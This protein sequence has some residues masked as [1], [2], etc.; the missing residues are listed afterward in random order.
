MPK[1]HKNIL[2]LPFQVPLFPA[3]G[4]E[5]NGQVDGR[6]GTPIP[7]EG[8]SG[9]VW[10][11]REFCGGIIIFILLPFRLGLDLRVYIELSHFRLKE[12]T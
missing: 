6:M 10:A 2:D 12:F 7:E 11:A 9:R 8:T 3:G 5:A 4:T 1:I